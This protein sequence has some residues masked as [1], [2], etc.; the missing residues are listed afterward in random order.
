[1]ATA[2]PNTMRL[3]QTRRNDYNPPR[4]LRYGGF[5][6][7][8]TRRG[9]RTLRPAASTPTGRRRRTQFRSTPA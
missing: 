3:P 5:E 1:M 8:R 9:L 2:I 4:A 6:R 7:V